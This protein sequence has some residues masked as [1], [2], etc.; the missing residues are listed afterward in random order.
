MRIVFLTLLGT[1]LLFSMIG[2]AL[3]ERPQI[4]R[5]IEIEASMSEIHEALTEL[6]TWS[7]WHP[8]FADPAESGLHVEYGE[9]TR[10]VGGQMKLRF[11]NQFGV[12]FTI[13]VSDPESGVEIELHSGSQEVDL[14][15]GEGALSLESIRFAPVLGGTEVTWVQTGTEAGSLLGRTVSA[16]VMRGR[17]GRQ[18]ETALDGLAEIV[19][20][21]E[22]S[23][24]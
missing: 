1:F 13:V 9:L 2:L 23:P 22:S 5:S 4:E 14:W 17:V 19:T 24:N 7:T 6:R 16:L 10:G 8:M 3:P 12:L 18:I 20:Q 15:R 21:D 11:S